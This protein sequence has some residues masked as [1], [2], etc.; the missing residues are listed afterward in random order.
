MKYSMVHTEFFGKKSRT[1]FPEQHEVKT[2]KMRRW[3]GVRLLQY[4]SFIKARFIGYLK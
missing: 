4:P 2:F 3:R 1:S